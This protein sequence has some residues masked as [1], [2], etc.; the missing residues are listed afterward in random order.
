M[1]GFPLTVLFG[2]ELRLR[3]GQRAAYFQVHQLQY[4]VSLI[5]VIK[6]NPFTDFMGECACSSKKH[7]HG[8]VC[9]CPTSGNKEFCDNCATKIEIDQSVGGASVANQN[10]ELV[11]DS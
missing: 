11:H 9:R 7:G 6:H 5:E 4:T 8:D 2:S 1:I 3:L 10:E